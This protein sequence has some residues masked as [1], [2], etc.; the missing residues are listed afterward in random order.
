M[1]NIVRYGC[2]AA[3]V[4]LLA[5]CG[6]IH[7]RWKNDSSHDI[8]IAY[9]KGQARYGVKIK[10]GREAVPLAPINFQS[11]DSIEVNDAGHLYNFNHAEILKLHAE[12]GHG[13]ACWIS[14]D[15]TH[16][17]HVSTRAPSATRT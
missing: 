13:F 15:D 4:A 7:P 9:L 5:G 10:R 14:Y 12:C 8:A 11:V 17:L 6:P 1:K 2:I 3:I 16:Q